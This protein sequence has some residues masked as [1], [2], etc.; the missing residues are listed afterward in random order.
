[1]AGILVTQV[2]DPVQSTGGAPTWT[3]YVVDAAQAGRPQISQLTVGLEVIERVR[4]LSSF[5]EARI[6]IST[7][8][9]NIG[10]VALFEPG[11]S[12][13]TEIDL[14]RNGVLDF[15]GVA[16]TGEVGGA[17]VP[18][19][20]LEL[21]LYDPTWYLTGVA[22]GDIAPA[23][24]IG[25][26][27]FETDT[28]GWSLDNPD[29]ASASF[30]S[31]ADYPTLG[32][33][34]G[35]LI[36]S[37]TPAAQLFAKA[38]FT[39]TTGP[40][41]RFYTATAYS[42]SFNF[43]APAFE[44]RGI[45]F[46]W[47]EQSDPLDYPQHFETT[48]LDDPNLY[49]PIRHQATIYVPPNTTAYLTLRLYGPYGQ[50]HWDAVSVV[51]NDAMVLRTTAITPSG[52]DAVDIAKSLVWYAQGVPTLL[53]PWSHGKTDY[54]I[55]LD[56]DAAGFTLERVY[57][58]AEKGPI[59]S[60]KPSGSGALDEFASAWQIDHY[61]RITPSDR[62]IVFVP[63][64]A[65]TARGGAL[66]N[67]GA[68]RNVTA[69]QVQRDARD[70]ANRVSVVGRGSSSYATADNPNRGSVPDYR[71]AESGSGSGRE[72]VV[73]ISDAPIDFLNELAD[74][75]LARLEDNLTRV[76]CE[77]HDLSGTQWVGVLEPGDTITVTLDDGWQTVN[78][79]MRVVQVT[80]D[81]VADV[82]EVELT[83]AVPD[84]VRRVLIPDRFGAIEQRV[85]RLERQV[86]PPPPTPALP[87]SWSLNV[88]AQSTTGTWE[89]PREARFVSAYVWLD[90]AT[91]GASTFSFYKN[92]SVVDTITVS[93]G[94]RRASTG[95]NFVIGPEDQFYVEATTV[96]DDFTKAVGQFE[97]V[98]I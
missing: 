94:Q 39:V 83:P 9:P 14:Y 47:R 80:H 7:S 24:L 19:G 96:G 62:T 8:D 3:A 72:K 18:D 43:N 85:D 23:N 32:S 46:G 12:Q 88:D 68:S 50:T 73:N 86:L 65:G 38:E 66:T 27:G 10:D 58:F 15:Q 71:G 36:N 61:L 26:S 13:L 33:K 70:L 45:L 93:N 20:V 53:N 48:Q 25:N 28:S 42:R 67:T 76:V 84:A 44:A 69:F 81:G 49:E 55:D 2:P 4:K 41:G 97:R 87:L 31:V 40:G 77:V 16:V 63:G 91:T 78:E 92:G 54:G 37:D 79:T 56:G 57:H 30:T 35:R 51:A 74:D 90:A 95:V 21:Q 60:G 34:S 5:G 29:G 59:W 52:F 11:Q 6:R 1:M 75:E 64:G 98:A 17:D 89:S 22:F 82:D